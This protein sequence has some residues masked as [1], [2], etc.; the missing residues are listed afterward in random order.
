M[1]EQTVPAGEEGTGRSSSMPRLSI[2]SLLSSEQSP[3][4]LAPRGRPNAEVTVKLRGSLQ[5]V[6]HTGRWART[7]PFT[8]GPA[9][10]LR[11]VSSRPGGGPSLN[12]TTPPLLTLR[13][14]RQRPGSLKRQRDQLLT[15]LQGFGQFHTRCRQGRTSTARS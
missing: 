15:G 13:L 6:V 7:V 3:A 11:S 12:R 5:A 2:V 4:D 1:A 14:R 8:H 9:R 10:P